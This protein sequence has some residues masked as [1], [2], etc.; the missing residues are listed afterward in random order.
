MCRCVEGDAVRALRTRFSRATLFKVVAFA[1]VS[2]LFTLA[3]AAR[4]GT[5]RPF[6]HTY[7]LQAVFAN[8]S[9]VFKGDAVKLAGVDVGRVTGAEIRGGQA[10]VTFDVDQ[11]VKLPADTV[12]SIRWRN[13]LGQR[14][15]YVYPGSANGSFLH[16]GSVIPMAQTQDAGDL[17]QFLNELGPILRAIDPEK[18]NAFLDAVN[19]ALSGNEANVRQLIGDGASLASNLASM[20]Q[21]IQTLISSSDTVISTYASQDTS[22]AGIIDNLGQLGGSL[23]G[24]RS[25]IDSLITNF[26]AVQQ[27]FD[28]LITTNRTN[29][30]ATLSSLDSVVSLL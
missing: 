7:R 14:F 18:A 2:A 23:N 11:A 9:G 27:E 12:V 29:I 13:V 30:D 8:A 16:D 10:L 15:L 4:I 1:L 22:I 25:D 3:L 20:D 19:G 5:L 21:Q 28:R 17:D 24:M 6:A 26:A